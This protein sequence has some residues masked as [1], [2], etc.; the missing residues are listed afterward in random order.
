MFCKGLFC[1]SN[2]L[3]DGWFINKEEIPFFTGRRC[4]ILENAIPV[5]AA[6]E[7]AARANVCFSGINLGNEIFIK[8]GQATQNT[9][10]YCAVAMRV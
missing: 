6:A 5:T 1:G 3:A 9:G 8:S 2:P 7:K 4:A 10:G